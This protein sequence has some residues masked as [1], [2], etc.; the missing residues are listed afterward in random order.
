MNMMSLEIECDCT[1]L[2]M[3]TTSN[4]SSSYSCL[5]R[6]KGKK[7]HCMDLLNLIIGYAIKN[8]S[9]SCLFVL[10]LW[11]PRKISSFVIF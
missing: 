2:K 6:L 3:Y 9:Y 1:I 5:H 10:V 4:S 8:I 7:T 11:C